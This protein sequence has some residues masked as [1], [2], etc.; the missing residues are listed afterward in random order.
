M[1]AL[2]V[3]INYVGTSSALRGCVNDV[4]ALQT[5]LQDN[6]YAKEGIKTL[7]NREATRANILNSLNNLIE[8]SE[9]GDR[10]FFHYSG[11]GTQTTDID[12]DEADGLDEALV[13]N[14]YKTA[15]LILDDELNE[16][17]E[18]LPANRTLLVLL[19]CCH[20]GSGLDLS[21]EWHQRSVVNSMKSLAVT[22]INRAV[23]L[24]T[25]NR[26]P[27]FLN[28]FNHEIQRLFNNHTS[29]HGYIVMLS[30]CRDKQTSADAW[31]DG[32]YRGATTCAFEYTVNKANRGLTKIYERLEGEEKMRGKVRNTMRRWL[33]EHGF[34]QKTVLSYEGDVS[35]ASPNMLKIS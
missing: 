20:S 33:S 15:G 2:L 14:D 27:E 13:P 22:T 29:E 35:A 24:P 10:L 6:G 1:K 31:I 19:D 3:G 9:P 17:I 23:A 30:G 28:A 25:E 26:A 21:H 8:H 32:A 12:G 5:L 7:L 18:K 16:I 4:L 34:S 11:H